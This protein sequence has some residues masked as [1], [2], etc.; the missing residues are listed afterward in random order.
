M[1]DYTP[2]DHDRLNAWFDHRG[3]LPDLARS[4]N[5]TTTQLADWAAQP[6]IAAAIA[7]IESAAQR[8]AALLHLDAQ[9]IAIN[10]LLEI[11]R[12]SQNEEVARRAA[13]RLLR[14]LAGITADTPPKPRPTRGQPSPRLHAPHTTPPTANSSAPSLQI[15]PTPPSVASAPSDPS[16]LSDPSAPS[17]LPTFADQLAAIFHK[18]DDEF[19]SELDAELADLD[20]ADLDDDARDEAED[21]AEDRVEDRILDRQAARFEQTFG[22]PITHPEITRALA[23]QRTHDLK[24]IIARIREQPH[25]PT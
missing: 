21:S 18:D 23:E 14:P 6:H 10:R 19:Q 4:L 9:H 24:H 2:A 15:V 12:T 7:R 20:N 1:S 22:V 5:I 16:A 8:R 25:A 11:A 13:D 17:A 3:Q